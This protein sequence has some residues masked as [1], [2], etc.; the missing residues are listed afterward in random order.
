MLS[1]AATLAQTLET[2]PRED[3]D[4]CIDMKYGRY[5]GKWLI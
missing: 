2:L 3:W 4:D 5:I 1:F